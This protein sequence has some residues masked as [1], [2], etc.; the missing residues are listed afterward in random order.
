MRKKFFML[1]FMLAT[2]LIST[3]AFA[4]SIAHPQ[5]GIYSIQ[6]KCAPGKE[7]SVQNHDRNWGAN[8]IIDDINSGWQKWKIQRIAGTD[9]YSIIAVRSGLAIDVAN[10]TAQNGINIATWPYLGGSQNQFRIWDAGNNYFVIQGNLNSNNSSVLDVVNAEN[11]A[12]TNVWSYS[13]NGSDAQLWRLEMRQPLPAFPPYNKTATK[14]VTAYV[15]PDLQATAG[16]EYVSAGDNVTVLREEGNAI[17]V[18]YPIRNGTK[19]RW[20]NK[21][22]IFGGSSPTSSDSWQSSNNVKVNLNVPVLKQNDPKWA[23]EKIN[24]DTIGNIGCTVTSLAMKYN[25]HKNA[26]ITPADVVKKLKSNN[27]FLGNNIIYGV[28]ETTFGYKH[29]I[30]DNKPSLN[31]AWMKEIY[32]QLKAGKPVIIGAYR[33]S[34]WQHWVIVK[35]YSGNSTTNFRAVDF[36]IND[37]QNNFTNLQEFI[38]KYYLGLRGIIY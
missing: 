14:K 34:K 28:V 6:P 27:G 22:E 35:G 7:L 16:N 38:N 25:Y 3:T 2:A 9:F 15:M 29:H 36:Q 4:Y 26:N 11:R 13:F 19:E 32:E 30:V 10:A 18:R 37:P 1:A 33:T 20:V 12:G 31:N 8:V 21:N 17:F 5:D 23:G 24:T